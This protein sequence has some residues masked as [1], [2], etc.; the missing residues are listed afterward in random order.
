M[1]IIQWFLSLYCMLFQFVVQSQTIASGV[2]TQINQGG[3]IQVGAECTENYFPELN[4]KSIGIVA[5]QTSM[6][7]S[8]N[9]VDSLHSCHFSIEKIFS[10]EHGFRGNEDAGANVGDH[11]DEKTSLPI[12]SLYGSKKKPSKVDLKNIQIL[13]Y[14]IQDV[15]VRFYT[16][17]S[18][19][20]FIM[21]SCA[22][23]DIELIILDRPNP[24]GYY[25]DG[26]VLEKDCKSFVGLTP[27]PIVYGMTCGEYANMLNG[28]VFLEDSLK[29]KLK[30]IKVRNYTHDFLYK[31]PISPSPNLTNMSAV[32]LYPS[33]GL[34]EGTSIS[35]G[36][37]TNKAFQVI[38]HPNLKKL[39]Y[40]F[41]PRSIKGASL[42]P[43]FQDTICYGNDLTDF[44]STFIKNNK[45]IYLF[46]IIELYKKLR[47][48][49]P[50]FNSFFD[51]LSG[52]KE[53]QKQIKEGKSEED[54]YKSWNEGIVNFKKTRKKYLL[55]PDFE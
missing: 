53:L 46:W 25:V 55:Y 31:L 21:E 5:N 26:P 48:Q 36:R 1:R 35:I 16:Y 10:L 27:I 50:F 18:S 33:L 2:G 6:I 34:F 7:G 39:D 19:L 30:V 29:C 15:G 22:E 32:Y 42:H 45:H 43:L 12:I 8:T 11:I 37:G 44:G 28:E 38:G 54:I 49:E 3:M 14:D 9:L 41:T 13:V 4:G 51:K 47:N 24:N 40:S 23:N 17:I 52:N 20:Q